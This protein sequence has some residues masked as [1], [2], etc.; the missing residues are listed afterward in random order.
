LTPHVA[1]LR[2]A[3]AIVPF[4]QRIEDLQARSN[5]DPE[6]VVEQE[7]RRFARRVAS[8]TGTRRERLALIA[9][10]GVLADLAKIGWQIRVEPDI[11]R[12]SRI[13]G[14]M[15]RERGPR[16]DRRQQL[17]AARTNALRSPTVRTFVRT[18]ER[19][20]RY[21]GKP[22]SIF[23]LMRDGADLAAA[24]A[25]PS[26]LDAGCRPYLQVVTEHG[27]CPYTG[28]RLNDIWRYFRL[29]WANAPRDVPARQLR[30]IVRDAG[31]TGHPVMGIGE[32]SGAAVKV[33][34]R[35]RYIGWDTEGY[36]GWWRA[37]DP[38]T[39]RSWLLAVV[40]NAAGEIYVDDFREE[41]ILTGALEA[42]PGIDSI[43]ELHRIAREMKAAHLART[44]PARKIVPS[45]KTDWVREAGEPLFRSK[46]AERVAQLLALWKILAP[47]RQDSRAETTRS[48][49]DSPVGFEAASK[50]VRLAKSRLQGTAIAD[51]TVCG[52]I[53]PYNELL[54]GKLVAILA[55]SPE[56]VEAYR[57]RYAGVPSIIASAMAG[58]PI[59]RPTDL[60]LVSTTGLYGVRP[61]QYDR[62]A[63]PAECV[64]AASGSSLR[65]VHLDEG[66]VGWGTFHFSDATVAALQKWLVAST[67]QRRV[68]YSYG[69]GANPRLRLLREGLTSLGLSPEELL[70]H[71]L[72]KSLYVCTLVNNPRRYLLGMDGVPEYIIP[73]DE[74]PSL[75]TESISAWWLGRWVQPRIARQEVL[76]RIRP[77]SL[78]RP[79]R[80]PARVDLPEDEEQIG[81]L[82]AW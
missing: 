41:E 17:L 64:G 15:P 4:V 46:R 5:D 18:L 65:Y 28:L 77:V 26:Y 68:T 39:L 74:S 82:E 1:D 70:F 34:P 57:D 32:L 56:I 43:A 21:Q 3:E 53:P 33:G 8:E 37:E 63:M 14:E 66:T 47:L 78:A 38:N 69:E 22:V 10:S 12:R 55:A 62:L 2:L 30:F 54:A 40:E 48:F 71:G 13:V 67:G 9:L 52:A 59:V 36:A 35:D 81:F 31:A 76:D 42:R 7:L 79:V 45:P 27:T 58:R 20:R 61:S 16:E 51:L 75:A 73:S 23:T 44:G 29:T 50:V 19:E 80:H 60:V 6:F 72:A 25:D 24:A 49:L 11:P